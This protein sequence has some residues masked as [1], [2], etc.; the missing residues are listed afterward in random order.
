MGRAKQAP[1]CAHIQISRKNLRESFRGKSK[2]IRARRNEFLQAITNAIVPFYIK[3]YVNICKKVHTYLYFYL[4]VFVEARI[5]AP[6]A[7]FARWSVT[8]ISRTLGSGACKISA[9]LTC[10]RFRR[11]ETSFPRYP[12]SLNSFAHFLARVN[13]RTRIIAPLVIGEKWCFSP[14]AR[15]LSFALYTLLRHEM[16]IT[17]DAL[18]ASVLLHSERSPPRRGITTLV[19]TRSDFDILV[20]GR[21]SRQG[22][23][24]SARDLLEI[25]KNRRALRAVRVARCRATA[26]PGRNFASFLPLPSTRIPRSASNDL[27][28]R[29]LPSRTFAVPT[30]DRSRSDDRS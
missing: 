20:H 23:G 5:G 4:S 15:A 14:R 12:S 9:R 6:R 16:S 22:G 28:S 21:R 30:R 18:I 25:M 26:P 1:L 3:L 2:H 19:R 10:L 29:G 24:G 27:G 8:K 7:R 17:V 11:G 13:D